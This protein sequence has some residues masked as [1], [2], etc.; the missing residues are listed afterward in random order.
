MDTI[1]APS[2]ANVFLGLFESKFIYPL[3]RGKCNLYTRFIDD[4]FLI[5][6]GT[7][8]ELVGTITKL[9][10]S[11]HSIKIRLKLFLL[12]NK[13]SGDFNIQG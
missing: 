12:R 10:A 2:Y 11:H 9:N 1:C 4:I 5:W 6:K 3:I 7:E 13:L 8:K